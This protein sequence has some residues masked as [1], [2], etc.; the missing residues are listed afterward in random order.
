MTGCSIGNL[1]CVATTCVNVSDVI[2]ASRACANASSRFGPTLPFVPA[3]ANVWQPPHAW[4]NSFL[5]APWLPS[6]V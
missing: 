6:L 4:M 5:P 1:I 2:P 3:S